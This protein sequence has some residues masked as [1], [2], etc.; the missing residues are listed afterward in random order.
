M[1]PLAN[2]RKYISRFQRSN[3]HYCFSCIYICNCLLERQLWVWF[4]ITLLIPCDFLLWCR[5][6][7]LTLLTLNLIARKKNCKFPRFRLW[8]F[9]VLTDGPFGVV[10]ATEL[11]GILLFSAYVI[12]N[13]IA[14]IVQEVS[15]ISVY[16]LPSMR[17]RYSFKMGCSFT[18]SYVHKELPFI[19]SYVCFKNIY[20][21][22]YKLLIGYSVNCM[23][24]DEVVASKSKI[25]HYL[26]YY[27]VCILA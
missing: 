18:F 2:C 7:F 9:P 13:I 19:Y 25:V 5:D 17:K 16:S 23:L 20:Y 8:T 21:Y 27:D 12:W 1:F 4:S 6:K 26:A 11:I 14:Y 22:Y 15:T 3:T 10:S 24:N